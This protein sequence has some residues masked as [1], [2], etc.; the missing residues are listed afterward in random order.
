MIVA[1]PAGSG[2]RPSRHGANKGNRGRRGTHRLGN[3]LHGT[4]VTRKGAMKKGGTGTFVTHDAI[5]GTVNTVSATSIT[6]TAADKVSE[7]YAV[8]SK[9]RVRVFDATTHK[10]VQASI[11]AVKSGQ[12]VIIAGTGKSTLTATR[13]VVA[14]KQK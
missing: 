8:T 14:K 3:A 4:W 13:V 7:T 6:V 12:K 11:S 2:A 1:G 5:R 9:T 10:P